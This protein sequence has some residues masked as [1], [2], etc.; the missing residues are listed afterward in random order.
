MHLPESMKQ[1]LLVPAL[2]I[3][4]IA[5]GLILRWHLVSKRDLWDDEAASVMFALLPWGSFLKGIWNY[6]AN[7]TFYYLL[8]RDWLHLGHSE[9]MIRGLSVLLGVA[10]IPATY[11][12]GKRLFGEKPA[13]VSAS[14]C[15]FRMGG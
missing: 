4:I 5:F 2:L 10:V 8:L 1:R 11:L 6:E 13:I 3:M 9:A 7:M 12:L 15:V 14:N